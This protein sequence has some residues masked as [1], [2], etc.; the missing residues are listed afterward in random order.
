MDAKSELD[1]GLPWELTWHATAPSIGV[2]QHIKLLIV[3]VVV[4]CMV[5]LLLR[6][7]GHVHRYCGC[8]LHVLYDLVAFGVN[9]DSSGLLFV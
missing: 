1:G 5:S 8:G 7:G 4:A 3:D 6:C 9:C 2:G